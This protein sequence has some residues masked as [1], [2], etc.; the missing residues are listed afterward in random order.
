MKQLFYLSLIFATFTCVSPGPEH[1]NKSASSPKFKPEEV[2]KTLPI[3]EKDIVADI[4]SGGG[5]YTFRFA[6]LVGR[7][8]KVFAV[9]VNKNFLA[10]IDK[11]KIKRNLTNIQTI[12]AEPTGPKLATNSIHLIFTRNVYHHL[13]NRS[14]YFANLKPALKKDGKVA[15][16]DYN[17][18]AKSNFIKS[19]KHFT[20]RKTIIQE[21][22]KAG[23][24]LEKDIKILPEQSFLIFSKTTK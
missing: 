10:Y 16:I 3:K 9:D 23:F 24:T 15:I 14:Q 20:P 8:G 7:Q 4:G 21:M 19:F 12:F 22:Q 18:H 13:K 1:F 6:K 5:Y 17:S 11:E 2:L